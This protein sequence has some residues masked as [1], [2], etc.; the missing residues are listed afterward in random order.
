MQ[1]LLTDTGLSLSIERN[2]VLKLY[3]HIATAMIDK[4]REGMLHIGKIEEHEIALLQLT[5]TGLSQCIES[6][7]VIKVQLRSISDACIEQILP[8]RK[9]LGNVR[10]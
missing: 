4:G 2:G 10:L 3:L 8:I 6:D 9:R 1:P 7:G 5:H